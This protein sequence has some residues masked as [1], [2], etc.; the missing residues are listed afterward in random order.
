LEDSQVYH[1]LV[2]KLKS[3]SMEFLFWLLLLMPFVIGV[4]ALT[5]DPDSDYIFR[6]HKKISDIVPDNGRIEKLAEG[7]EL[8]EGPV[9][10]RNGYFLFSDI[11]ANKVLKWE[12]GKRIAEFFA[13]SGY[14]GP[15]ANKTL[16]Y[17]GS[18]GLAIDHNGR[19]VLCEQGNRRLTR[20]EKNRT[21]T[22][23]ADNY[24][25]KRLNSPNDVVIK[26]DGSIY[27]TDPPY[28]L[29]LMESDPEKELEF[30]GVYRWCNGELQLLV[31]DMARPNGLAFSPDEKFL[32]IANSEENN[33][34]WMRYEVAEDGTLNNGIV[35]FNAFGN[36]EDGLPD[37]MKIDA[38]GN[39]YCTGPGGIWI[40]SPEGEYLGKIKIPE[41]PANCAWGGD[42]FKTLFITARTS[43]YSIK[44]L[45]PGKRGA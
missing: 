34:L 26:S 4:V 45:V 16:T 6:N 2:K 1:V 13:P 30:S 21:I 8:V 43:L 11:A 38:N 31:S 3:L 37:G 5:Q 18:N 9:W 27:F 39:L 19:L 7:F 42:D 29:N 28:G 41:I 17:P 40:F 22:V 10:V 24:N 12:P 14:Y 44:L 32:Y 35:F 23:L 20:L 36:P 25:G 15:D 33:M